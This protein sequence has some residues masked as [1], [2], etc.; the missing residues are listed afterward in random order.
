MG[1]KWEKR[2]KNQEKW[3]KVTKVQAKKRR[4]DKFGGLRDEQQPS[5]QQ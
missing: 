2:E 3:N 1:R 5:P 4:L